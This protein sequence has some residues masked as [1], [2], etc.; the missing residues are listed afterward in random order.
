MRYWGILM[1]I[2][3]AVWIETVEATDKADAFDKMRR[4]DCEIVILTHD[5]MT[6]LGTV[7]SEAEVVGCPDR[8][9]R[10]TGLEPEKVYE[11]ICDHKFS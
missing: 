1:G 11:A 4:D 2:V 5:E 8:L 10:I 7:I 9:M 6:T 3:G